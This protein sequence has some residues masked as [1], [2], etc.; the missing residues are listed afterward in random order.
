MNTMMHFLALVTATLVAVG[1]AALLDWLLL[2]AIFRLLEPARRR[3]LPARVGENGL[4]RGT[5]LLVRAYG[6]QR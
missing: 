2:H 5:A 4:V 3:P 1:I 6:A